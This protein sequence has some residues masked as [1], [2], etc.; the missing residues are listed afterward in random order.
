MPRKFGSNCSKPCFGNHT[1]GSGCV[2]AI[3]EEPQLEVWRQHA[4]D[5]VRVGVIETHGPT[6][7]GRV[8]AERSRHMA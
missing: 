8:A 5:G 6:D 2:S 3:V 1:R 4:D 7:D